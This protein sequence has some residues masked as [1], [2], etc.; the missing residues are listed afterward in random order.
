MDVFLISRN[1]RVFQLVTSLSLH[2]ETATACHCCSSVMA[3]LTAQTS[4]MNKTVRLLFAFLTAYLLYLSFIG[5]ILRLWP[6]TVVL[7][8]QCC[9]H[10]FSACVPAIPISCSQ[11]V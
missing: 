10:F 3:K 6:S 9:R 8:W 4:L 1:C 11:L 5:H 2:A 7:A